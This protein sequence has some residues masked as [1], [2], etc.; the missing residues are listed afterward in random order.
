MSSDLAV[1]DTN[2]LVYALYEE[3]DYFA[4]SHRLLQRT[5]DGEVSLCLPPQVLGELYAVITS[6]SRVTNPRSPDQ[7]VQV[8]EQLLAMP[9]LSL[10]PVPADVVVRWT[11]LARRYPVTGSGIFDLQLVATMLG[12]GIRRIYTFDRSDFEP[13]QGIEVLVP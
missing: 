4:S 2:V 12:N 10:L 7:A 9:G 3:S 5:Q 11:E 1:V 8:V 6:P 13:I